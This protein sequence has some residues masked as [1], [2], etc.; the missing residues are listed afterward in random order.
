MFEKALRKRYYL[1]NFAE[2]GGSGII[3]QN[4]S[5]RRALGHIGG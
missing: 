3:Y 5:S 2:G 1:Q 4:L